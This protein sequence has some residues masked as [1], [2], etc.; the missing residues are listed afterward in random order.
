MMKQGFEDAFVE[1]QSD[2]V[3]LGMELLE[4]IAEEIYIYISLEKGEELFNAFAKH[5]GQIRGLGSLISDEALI[6][7]FLDLGS[8][9]LPKIKKLCEEYGQPIPTQIKMHYEVTTGKY[10]ADI[11]YE[12]QC[13][14]G[15][16]IDSVQNFLD[17][18]DEEKKNN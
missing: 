2:F 16:D 14:K 6:F 11:K 15:T 3:S 8:A 5:N 1:L 18:F 10:N 13:P 17:W 12:P 4:G 9:D 7:E